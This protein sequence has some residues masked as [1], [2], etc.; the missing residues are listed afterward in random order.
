[1]TL[2]EE[3]D[4]TYERTDMTEL[5]DTGTG[6]SPL[7]PSPRIKSALREAIKRINLS[8]DSE[9]AR[10]GRFFAS[11]FGIPS[12]RICLATSVRELEC[13]AVGHF[14]PVRVIIAGPAPGL[15]E[16]AAKAAGAEVSYIQADPSIGFSADPS[17][18]VD[19]LGGAGLLFIANPNRLTGRLMPHDELKTIL[20]G[21]AL[22]G[23]RVVVDESLLD[24]TDSAP[25]PDEFLASGVAISLKTTA[26][27]HGVPGLE[28]A[29]AVSSE[30]VVRGISGRVSGQVDTLS[31]V[32]ARAGMRD[33]AYRRLMREFTASERGLLMKTLGRLEGVVCYPSD[34]NMLLIKLESPDE[35][36]F[37]SLRRAG[38]LVRRCGDVAGL[39]DSFISIS[40]MKHDKNKKF[41][42]IM[43][44]AFKGREGCMPK[45]VQSESD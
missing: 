32:A 27:Y 4:N 10:F 23:V 26:L 42:R 35:R 1:M 2:H 11:R 14:R 30:E 3:V 7:G 28:L 18:I 9:R 38:F 37:G 29:W 16:E 15:Y 19:R 45:D 40:L 36:L 43:R 20:A 8:P 33:P 24:F 5:I 44:E 22:K 12:G 13:A 6:V 21:A 17:M 25:F 39:D 41:C 31:L 34:S